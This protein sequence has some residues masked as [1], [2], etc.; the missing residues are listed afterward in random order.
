MTLFFYR[1]SQGQTD[2]AVELPSTTLDVYV[3]LPSSTIEQTTFHAGYDVKAN[4]D[5]SS[6]PLLHKM[7]ILSTYKFNRIIIDDQC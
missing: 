1:A 3:E 6:F 7:N 4:R 5:I 2:V